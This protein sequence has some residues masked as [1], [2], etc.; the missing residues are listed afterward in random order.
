MKGNR[1]EGYA[2]V[3][4]TAGVNTLSAAPAKVIVNHFVIPDAI[5]KELQR[6]VNPSDRIPVLSPFQYS[7]NKV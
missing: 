5:L 2:A 4:L 6:M 7:I 3:R 1:L